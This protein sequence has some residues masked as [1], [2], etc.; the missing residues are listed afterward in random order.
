MTL[1]TTSYV[2][3][4]LSGPTI[5]FEG[6]RM[7]KSG[8]PFSSR[9]GRQASSA[10]PRTQ[11]HVI[12]APPVGVPLASPPDAQAVS[13]FE[14]AMTL[15]QQHNYRV[16]LTAFEDLVMRFPA[17]AALLDRAR[18]YAVL[19]QRAL[20]GPIETGPRTTEEHLTAA[21]AALNNGDDLGAE[22]LLARVLDAARSHELVHYLLAVVYAR[23]GATAAALDALR[24]AIA[25]NPEVRAQAIHDSDFDALRRVEAFERLMSPPPA[26]PRNGRDA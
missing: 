14:R 25:A 7:P 16:A 12:W 1:T 20:A 10:K 22:R 2:W 6:F 18:S 26:Q 23:R 4:R 9:V 24:Q 3:Y 13:V 15:L 19:C 17:E 21:T 5:L 11:P 8:L